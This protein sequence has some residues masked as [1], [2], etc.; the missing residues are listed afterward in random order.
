MRQGLGLGLGLL[1]TIRRLRVCVFACVCWLGLFPK[2]VGGLGDG[3][4]N[5]TLMTEDSL[6][7]SEPSLDSLAMWRGGVARAGEENAASHQPLRGAGVAVS[8][9]L[10]SEGARQLLLIGRFF[11]R[12][13]FVFLWAKESNVDR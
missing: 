10:G 4:D 12:V 11:E 7:F 2:G 1:S 3:E 9:E 5:N 13:F 8:W 6:K